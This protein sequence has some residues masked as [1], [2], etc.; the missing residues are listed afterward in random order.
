MVTKFRLR[1]HLHLD[2][3]RGA[4]LLEKRKMPTTKS[5]VNE[6]VRPIA[7]ISGFHGRKGDRQVRAKTIGRGLDNVLAAADALH[8]LREGLS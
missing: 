4:R 3:I 7:Q 6:V 8:A 1:S 2:E 5:S